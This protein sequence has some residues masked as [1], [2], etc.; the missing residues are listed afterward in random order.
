MRRHVN[1]PNVALIA[2][3]AAFIAASTAVPEITLA[4]GVPLTLQTFAVVLAGLVLGPWRGFAAFLLYLVVGLAGAP[5]FANNLGGIGVL[6]GATG[7]YLIGMA[8]AAIVVGALAVWNRRRGTLN[9]GTLI[10]S[11][12]ASIPVI[13]AVGVPWLAMRTGLPVWQSAEG[14][15]SI[16][17]TSDTCV[18][19]LSVG[20]IPFLPGDL[21]K[22]VLAAVVA[23][24]IHRAYPQ[25]LPGRRV[26]VAETVDAKE[27]S[28]A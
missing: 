14:C 4:F 27:S 10:L 3:F 24:I 11:G 9:L 25:L 13:Y 26:P 12:L 20:V 1:G 23:N 19:A 2:V 5:I 22:V 21:I 16:L 15:S 17:D 28:T 8:F 7:G 18:T 6:A